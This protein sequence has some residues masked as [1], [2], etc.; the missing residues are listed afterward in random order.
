MKRKTSLLS[1]VVSGLALLFLSAAIAG[2]A[3]NSLPLPA[4]SSI[5]PSSVPAGGAGFT[6][7]VMGTGFLNTDVVEWNG[8][9]LATEPVSSTELDAQVPASLIQGAIQ[10]KAG[11]R[12]ASFSE[13]RGRRT[14]DQTTGD[15][16]VEITVLQKPPGS[17]LS[18]TMTFT[19][20][21]GPPAPD[22]SISA[23]PSSQTLTAGQG[24]SYSATIAAL[25]GFTGAVNLTVSGF[26]TGASGSFAP[27]TVTGS[28]TSGLAVST[29]T[30]TAAGSYTLTITGTS[31]SLTH[32]TTV[33][34]VVNAAPSQDFSISA[35][36]SSE[37]VTSGGS[38]TYNVTIS[39][40][41]GFAGTVT[42]GTNSLP[43][44]ATASF[45]RTTVPGSGTSVLTI[46][47]GPTMPAP[48]PYTFMITGTSGSL[49]HSTDVALTVTA[50]SAGGLFISTVFIPA[51]VPGF[52]NVNAIVKFGNNGST[53]ISGVSIAITGLPSATTTP[54]AIVL[55][56]AA[57][58]CTITN[59]TCTLSG[60][61]PAGSD[62]IV[63]LTFQAVPGTANITGTAT[64]SASG[65]TSASANFTT[66]TM[67]CTPGPGV[68]CG[69]YLLF[70]QGYGPDTIAINFVADGAGNLTTGFVDYGSSGAGTV[71]ITSGSGYSFDANGLG[72]LTINT[73]GNGAFNYIFKF[74]LDP[75]T[76]TS[77]SVIEYE[78]SGATF[79]PNGGLENGSG[80]LQLQTPAYYISQIT[81]SYSL[82]LIGARGLSTVRVGML[83]AFTTNG[84]CSVSSTGA[85]GAI[86]DG[87]TLSRS[88][89][90]SGSLGANGCFVSF[91]DGQGVG[92]FSSISGTPAP[93]FAKVD[94]DYYILDTNPDGT[95]NHLLVIEND[96]PPS[97]SAP[98]LSGILARQNTTTFSTKGALDCA[99]ASNL[100]CV[101]AFA[102]ATGGDSATGN[103]YV[104]AGLASIT[105]QSNT[106][107]ALSLL[108]DENN[109]G[110]VNS[111]TITAT[112]SY[113]ADG[114]GSFTP[115]SGE[116][117]DFILTDVDTGYVLSEGT[118]VS[119]GF[120]APESS[121]HG[122]FNSGGL[123][124]ESFD[125]GTRYLGMAGATTTVGLA[126]A[127]QVPAGS[128]TGTFS[129]N[130]AFW[131]TGTQQNSSALTGTYTADP[132]TTRVTGTTNI[133][134]A[135]SFA[136][137][138]LGTNQFVLVGT[139]SDDT[140]AVLMIF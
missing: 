109:G 106:A 138:Q 4:I 74:A 82:A 18:N 118:N 121:P 86:N 88:V 27:P 32:S 40:L 101:F 5:S 69:Q 134:G 66:S 132:L 25:N 130:I 64:L 110:T 115:T 67:N 43:G 71:G 120:F 7:K 41:N 95:A 3:S 87:G 89:S 36:P 12:L 133:P 17:V 38:T 29:T 124:T 116:V 48:G 28:G 45:N 58:S 103:S 34:L 99:L 105:T 73:V 59:L 49:M 55:L 140:E 107:G 44:G 37:T 100:G 33:T 72:N 104:L 10:A 8:Q 57:G 47:T 117:I 61:L 123:S 80:F 94:F 9:V 53:P 6:L 22:F 42:L 65:T 51:S 50:A 113:K 54:E 13:P 63:M 92:T 127:T 11:I 46:G 31:G 77:G 83:G 131:N 62:P 122:P 111:G 81:G 30:S 139:A 125:T 15:V 19:I 70:V 16:T 20:V 24:T 35:T 114:T 21:T 56:G 91:N 90:F 23:S 78:P 26:P 85:T 135:A 2:C 93:S 1:S 136:I 137:Y 79:A 96:T 52:T 98:R 60:P 112:Y 102:G 119:Y 97:A 75:G 108:R 129:G 84:S 128:T 126:K 76:G 14:P 68:L 39:P